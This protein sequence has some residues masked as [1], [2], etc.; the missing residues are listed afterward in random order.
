MWES[1]ILLLPPPTCIAR[2]I[3]ILLHVYCA[4]YDAP[5]TPPLNAIHYTILVM[6][7]SCKGQVSNQVYNKMS[8]SGLT[9][10]CNSIVIWRMILMN[11]MNQRCTFSKVYAVPTRRNHNGCEEKHSQHNSPPCCVSWSVLHCRGRC[12][13]GLD[14]GMVGCCVGVLLF[15]SIGR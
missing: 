2:I 7:I 4:R 3:A 12:R 9:S 14:H 10:G 6:A 8:T 13:R 11:G 5:P 15:T 1:I